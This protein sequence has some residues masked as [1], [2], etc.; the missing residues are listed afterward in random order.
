M[1]GDRSETRVANGLSTAID[2]LSGLCALPSVA[3]EPTAK[4]K[5]AN[6]LESHLASTGFDVRQ[7]ELAGA[8]PAVYGQ[9]RGRSAYILLLYNHYDVQP[10]EPLDQWTTPPFEPSLRDGKLFARGVSD[11]KGEIVARL[12]AIREL[13]RQD[14]ELPISIRWIIEGEEEVGSPHFEALA[15]GH[16]DLL[17]ADG[18]LWEGASFDAED[19]PEITLGTKGLLY[20]QLDV[21]GASHDAHSGVAPI[22]PSA[23][24]RL[25]GALASLRAADGTIRI[26]GFYDGVRPP[27]AAQL[28][29]LVEQTDMETEMLEAFGLEAF[30]DGLTG[31]PLRQRQAFSPTG[32]IAGL[33]SGYTDA[34]VKTVLPARAMAKMDFRLVPDQHPDD[35]LEKLVSHLDQEGYGDVQVTRLGEAEPVVTPL[36][37]PFVQRVMEIAGQFSG[38]RPAIYPLVGGTLPLLGALRRHVGVPGLSAPGNPTYWASGAHGPNEHIRLSDLER[39][40]RFNVALFRSLGEA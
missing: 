20:V 14:G 13:L 8:P 6:L 29:A 22:L 25:V 2:L 30:V 10:A 4:K 33:L 35:V 32:N 31:L 36:E 39:A 40:M 15:E 7:I 26:P 12:V 11:N 34:G 21:Q 17:R 38:K 23:A 3:V 19:R 9:L 27:T 28:G 37:H 18:C 1:T 24:W 16:S 5:T